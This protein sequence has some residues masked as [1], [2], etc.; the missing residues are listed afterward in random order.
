MR[1]PVEE[2]DKRKKMVD[3]HLNKEKYVDI[4]VEWVM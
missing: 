2:A 4:N 3:I 1:T